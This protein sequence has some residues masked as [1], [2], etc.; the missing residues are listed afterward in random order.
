MD[1]LFSGFWELVKKFLT[2]VFSWVWSAAVEIFQ[3]FW[4]VAQ[5]WVAFFYD[6]WVLLSNNLL[7]TFWTCIPTGWRPNVEGIVAFLNVADQWVP[8]SEFLYLLAG[9]SVFWSAFITFKYA[10]RLIPVFH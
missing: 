6:T 7:A 3:K 10:W 1:W 5:N 9:L 8:V 2:V 4:D